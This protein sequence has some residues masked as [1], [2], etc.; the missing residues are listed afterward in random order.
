MS[1]TGR[2]GPGVAVVTGAGSGIGEAIAGRLVDEGC[3]VVVFD[4][5]VEA[6]ERV[7]ADI[8][9]S[10]KVVDVSD[11]SALHEALAQVGEQHGPLRWLVNNAGV[12]NLKHLHDYTEQEVDLIW[13]VNVSGTF[14]G[15]QS[16]SRLMGEGSSILNV[17]SV[18]GVRP[19]RGEAPYSAAKAAVVALTQAAA[20]ELAPRIRV[21]CVSPGFVRTP[22]N[23]MLAGDEQARAAIEKGTPLGRVGEVDDVAS[24]A[25]F[26]LSDEAAYLTGQNV[27]LDGGSMLTSSQMDPVL[28]PL[29][30]RFNRAD[31]L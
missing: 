30:E 19:T 23:E 18:S 1:G 10:V 29:I 24:L 7:A 13:R 31:H 20:L 6:A 28:I 5:D 22:L 16:A 26:L 15:I 9:A 8:G 14:W 3:R 2:F 25:A 17:A 12:G 4:R 27:V 21:N 11:R